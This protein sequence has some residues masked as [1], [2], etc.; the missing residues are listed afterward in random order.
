MT[1]RVINLRTKRKQKARADK[2][3]EADANARQHGRSKAERELT[4]AQKRIEVTRLDGHRLEHPD[5][6]G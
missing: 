2:R 4:E 6:D 3:T 1:G 5:D